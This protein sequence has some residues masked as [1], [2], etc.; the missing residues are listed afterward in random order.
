[1]NTHEHTHTPPATSCLRIDIQ[2]LVHTTVRKR[3][4]PSYDV[5]H[6][7]HAY[8][9]RSSIVRAM[10]AAVLS[11]LCKEN[12][13]TVLGA[14]VLYELLDRV[15]PEEE[16]S[17]PGPHTRKGAKPRPHRRP[18]GAAAPRLLPLTSTLL[19][20]H[21]HYCAKELSP[22]RTAAPSEPPPRV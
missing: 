22:A 9:Q 1:M 17:P 16:P 15:L 12:G 11:V 2:V 21:P 5:P 6:P 4:L 20:L 13:I 7:A 8:H 10:F 14:C 18:L 19:P 3:V